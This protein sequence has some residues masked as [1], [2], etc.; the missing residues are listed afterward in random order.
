[1]PTLPVWLYAVVNVQTSI[2][3]KQELFAKP[4]SSCGVI[5]YGFLR[6]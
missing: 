1:M 4:R 3:N 2:G 5:P 6:P